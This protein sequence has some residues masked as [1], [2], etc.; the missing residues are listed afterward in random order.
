[1]LAYGQLQES[2][3]ISYNTVKA[4][5]TYLFTQLLNR[6]V[7]QNEWTWDYRKDRKRFTEYW[8]LFVS[9]TQPPVKPASTR[10]AY[11]ALRA[12]VTKKK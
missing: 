6:T 7:T 3:L 4:C 1:M 11:D 5:N 8:D 12:S 10:D 2:F 9:R